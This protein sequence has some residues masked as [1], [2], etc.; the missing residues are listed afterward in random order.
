[1]RRIFLILGL[2]MLVWVGGCNRPPSQSEASNN[3]AA[4]DSISVADHDLA[5]SLPNVDSASTTVEDT[6]TPKGDDSQLPL[7][8]TGKFVELEEGDYLHFKMRDAADGK[9]KSFFLAESLPQSAWMPFYDDIGQYKL[10]GRKVEITWRT[11]DRYLKHAGA[12]NR[13]EEVTS[14]KLVK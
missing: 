1:M 13:I 5:D 10:K 4:T 8:M 2:G 12:T 14:I 7:T 9:V 11:I 6:A 3:N